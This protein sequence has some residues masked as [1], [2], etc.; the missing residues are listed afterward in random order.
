MIK[1][2][3]I[4]KMQ[5]DTSE[6]GYILTSPDNIKE[7]EKLPLIVF[8]HG[9]GERGND[10]EKL[11]VYC[12]PKLFTKNQEHNGIRAYTLSPQCPENTTWIDY[13]KELVALI[14]KV[15]C[16]NNIDD[17]MVS[18][19][20]ISMG[21]F[22]T[23]EL[24]LTYPY[25]FHKIAPLCGGGMNWR[26]WAINMPVRAFHGKLDDVV[27]ISQSEAMVNSLRVQGKDVELIVYDDLSHNCWDRA[28]EQ[29]DLI[30]WLVK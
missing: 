13:K 5:I 19:C 3:K 24:A 23:W 14:D 8:L 21:G 10:L 6:L 2:E 11:K 9:A 17:K 30:E 20:G 12:I 16:E 25:K 27:P 15:I 28:F 1:H 4:E 18:L 29:T 26:A 7:G 22:G